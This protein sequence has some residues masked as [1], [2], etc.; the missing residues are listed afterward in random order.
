MKNILVAIDF[1]DSTPKLIE[2]A[3]AMGKAFDAKLWLIHIAPEEPDF[4]GYHEGPQY[5]RDGFAKELREEHKK[6][7]IICEGLRNAGVNSEGLMVQGP[8]LQM[9][10]DE[11]K[12]LEVEMII[13]CTHRRNFFYKAFFGSVSTELFEEADIP[14]LAIPA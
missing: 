5:V 3:Q 7:Q 11:S 9:L 10:L 2:H 8:T 1:D 13:T 4:V 14:I 12:K 6:L